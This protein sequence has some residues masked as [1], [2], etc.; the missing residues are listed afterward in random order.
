MKIRSVAIYLSMLLILLAFIPAAPVFADSDD[1]GSFYQ[2][3][4]RE[5]GAVMLLIDPETGDIVFANE[6]AAAFYGYAVPELENMKIQEINTLSPAETEAEYTAAARE[7]RNYFLFRH[8]LASGEIRDVEVYS[9]PVDF[10]GQILLFSVIT[11]ITDRLTAQRSLQERQFILI[12]GSAAAA[13][14]FIIIS[15]YL[16]LLNRQRQKAIDSFAYWQN[17]MQYIIHHAPSAIAVHDKDLRYLFVSRKYLD[18]YRV[19][20][21]NVIGKHHYEVFPDIPEKWRQVHQRILHG[22]VESADDDAFERQD[23]SIDYTRWEGRPWYEED[24]SI[25]GMIIYTE[26]INERKQ[27]EREALLAL[28]QQRQQ[29]KLE[30]IGT[31]ASGVAHE[32]N[33]PIMGIMNYAQLI[34]DEAEKES[35]SFTFANEIIAESRRISVIVQDLLFFARHEKQAHSPA[36]LHDIVQRTLSLINSLIKKDQISITVDLP[37]ELP[38][39]KCRSQQIQQ[40]VMNL[41][42]NARDALNEKYPGFN[43]D[44]IIHV[45]GNLFLQENRRWIRL[46]VEDHGNGIP[47]EIQER[48]FDPFF[49][50]K[51]RDMGTG[52][53]LP[54]SYGIIKE[55]HGEIS[56]ETEQGR[57]TR[58]HVDLPV[59]N[60]WHLEH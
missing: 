34:L 51:G 6:A 46:T 13:L 45:S 4:F 29:Q 40:V 15:V 30:A 5:H 2:N 8:R 39:L 31:L 23:G 54:I 25:G 48:L 38:Q 53:G 3:L 12:W 41:L 18:D 50:T 44:K 56:F 16:V 14:V 7:D 19:E 17:L 35:Q 11:D 55:H 21:K 32:I 9:Y 26:V 58:F 10:D 27:K 36:N 49:T 1:S 52:L 20:E 57:F 33:N 22:S 24:G 47:A 43:E 60:G 42:T 28:Q 37:D 59:D